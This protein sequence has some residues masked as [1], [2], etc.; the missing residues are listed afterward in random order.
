MSDEFEKYLVAAMNFGQTRRERD[1][2][3]G[4]RFADELQELGAR[5]RTNHDGKK[6]LLNLL[7]NEDQYVRSWAAKD[8]LFFA[9]E[10]AVPV[11]E[12]LAQSGGMLALSATTTLDEWRAGQLS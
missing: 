5:I 6:Y 12:E 8:C 3:A 4:N 9:P 1:F 11:L 7:S 2:V 10:H